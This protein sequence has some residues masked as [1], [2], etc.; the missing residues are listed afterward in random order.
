MLGGMSEC[1]WIT[2]GEGD[3]AR[4]IRDTFADAGFE[5]VAPG[6][7]TLD[8]ADPDSVA[9]F[10]ARH[11]APELLVCQAGAAENALLAR[12]S[13]A[14]WDRQIEVNLHGA[15]RCARAVLPA[16]VER[17]RGHVVFVSSHSAHHPPPGQ[18]AY[19][20]AKAGLIG[21][22]RSLAAEVGPH[23]P[24]VN[25]VLPGFLETRMTAALTP[26][27]RDEVRRAHHLRR[28]NTPEA[29]AKF[30]LHLHRDLPH[31]SGQVFSLDSR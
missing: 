27:R 19:A 2:G 15:F 21:L 20:A 12:C 30:L 4:R 8:V 28:F 7:R 3:L 26:A 16:M 6:R 18:A 22:A 5:V 1:V 17:G 14:S 29:A 25:T 9:E 11:G 31:T 23:G 10:A 13:E 24:R